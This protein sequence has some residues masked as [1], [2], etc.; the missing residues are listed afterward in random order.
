MAKVSVIVPVYKVEKYIERCAKSLFEQ[1]LQDIEFIF[2]DD[3]TTDK[4]IDI[5]KKVLEGYPNRIKQTRIEKMAHNSG[6]PLV[7]KYG[8]SLSTGD[9]IIACDSDDYVESNMYET[10]YQFAVEGNYDLVHC[11]ID[12]VNDDGVVETL[13]TNRKVLTSNELRRQ[14]IDGEI[15]N[16]LCNKL[17]RKEVYRNIN[18]VFPTFGMDEDNA[19]AI[20]LAYFSSQLG[21]INKAFYKAYLNTNSISRVSGDQMVIKKYNESLKNSVLIL[22]FLKSHGYNDSDIAVIRAKLRPK[23][24]LWSALN[25]KQNITLWINTYADINYTVFLSRKVSYKTKIKF[26][27][28][29]FILRPYYFLVS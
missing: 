23:Q 11:D 1:T 14:I 12:I 8:V 10:M 20:Q 13:S 3:C 28:A 2:V 25:C 21:Y 16:S 6:L 15:S 26:L 29:L 19:T 17:V 4:S 5:L 22:D 18:I 27:I 24:I 9:Y 7:R